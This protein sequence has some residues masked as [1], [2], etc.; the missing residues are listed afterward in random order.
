MSKELQIGFIA[1]SPDYGNP[2]FTAAAQG[3]AP[4][5]YEVVI[6][7][8]RT[9]ARI[10]AEIAALERQLGYLKSE[11]SGHPEYRHSAGEKP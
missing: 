6:G 4:G 11:M 9:F 10:Q 5:S 3:P 2:K 1:W 7:G 8:P